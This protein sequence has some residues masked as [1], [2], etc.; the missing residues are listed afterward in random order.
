MPTV[1]P[2]NIALYGRTGSGKTTAADALVRNYGYVH[3]KTGGAC[4][5]LC[6]ELFGSED[7][8]L[9]NKVTD[10]LRSIDPAVWLRAALRETD[11]KPA[12]PIVLDSI[13]F[14][15]DYQYV[16]ERDFAT[17]RITAPSDSRV[18]RLAGRGQEFD[19][20]RDDLHPAEI[21]LASEEFDF[22]IENDGPL[23]DL[24]GD[25]E[26]VANELGL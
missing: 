25:I 5:A 6:L 16:I 17:I 26:R 1:T 4:R 14:R 9:M 8:A 2:R 12:R 19:L 7:K 23:S 11:T 20:L 24:M 3:R 10:A 21:E 15:P 13:R 18:E 22:T